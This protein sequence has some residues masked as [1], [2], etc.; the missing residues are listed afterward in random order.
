MIQSNLIPLTPF[1]HSNEV[2]IQQLQAV[3]ET[4]TAINS[5]RDRKTVILN[6]EALDKQEAQRVVDW[7]AGSAFA[8]HGQ[9]VWIENKTFLF[10]PHCVEVTSPDIEEFPPSPKLG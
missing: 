5:L 9:T 1:D 8:I 10:V 7:M 2:I 6:L 4:V 3:E